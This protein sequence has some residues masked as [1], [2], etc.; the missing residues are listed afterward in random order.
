M[1][2]EALEVYEKLLELQPSIDAFAIN[3]CKFSCVLGNI[4][5]GQ[6]Y[7]EIAEKLIDES[8]PNFPNVREIN[9]KKKFIQ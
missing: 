8:N 6:K 7:L 1:S 3:C 4:E 9:D 5:K 2:S